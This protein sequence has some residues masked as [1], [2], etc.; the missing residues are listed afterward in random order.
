MLKEF[1]FIIIR[2]LNL[3]DTNRSLALSLNPDEQINLVDRQIFVPYPST[4]SSPT[5]GEREPEG[6]L[7]SKPLFCSGRGIEVRTV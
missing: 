3:Y 5:R 7:G 4:P 2:E 1:R 6:L